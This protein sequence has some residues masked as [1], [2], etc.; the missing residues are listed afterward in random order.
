MVRR[1]REMKLKMRMMMMMMWWEPVH[2]KTEWQQHWLLRNYLSALSIALSKYQ[3]GKTWRGGRLRT[4]NTTHY[5][6]QLGLT[7]LSYASSWLP[8]L[9]IRLDLFTNILWLGKT[10]LILFLFLAVTQYTYSLHL[11]AY[12][13]PEFYVYY[14][15][16]Y[17]YFIIEIHISQNLCVG[18]VSV[19]TSLNTYNFC[20]PETMCWQPIHLL[21]IYI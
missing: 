12:Y 18:T 15:P 19:Y 7:P 1:R 21:V 16:I 8:R 14:G 6:G 2:H 20:V 10:I 13:L 4:V 11:Y 5:R 17:I 9:P 3:A